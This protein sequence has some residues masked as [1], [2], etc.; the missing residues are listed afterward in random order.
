MFFKGPPKITYNSLNFT[1][2]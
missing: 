2:F 1:Y